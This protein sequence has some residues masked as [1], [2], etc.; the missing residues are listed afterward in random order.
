MIHVQLDESALDSV[1]SDWRRAC[2]EPGVLAL[3]P[4]AEKDRLTVLQ[5]VCRRLG[6]PL[7]GA[8]FPALVTPAGFAS[9]GA[10]LLRLD[11]AAPTALVTG[12]GHD[13]GR[14][15]ARLADVVDGLL[16]GQGKTRHAPTLYLFF[17]AMLPNIAST[18]A[19]LYLR[20]G[21]R[22]NYAGVNAG[23]ERFQPM[24]CLFD[25]RQCLGDGVLCL[26]L[27]GEVTT[28]LDHGF[29]QP[30]MATCTTVTEGNRIASINGRPA[31]DV[32]RELIR[33]HYAID[34]TPENFYEYGVHFPFGLLESSKEMAVRIPVAI[35]GDGS[36]LC[37][38]EV[39][40]GANL[41][42]MKAP[43]IWGNAYTDRIAAE[44][45]RESIPV[46]ERKFLFFYCAG[47]RTHIGND[48]HYEIAALSARLGAARF[49]GALS[50][51]EIG[52]TRNDGYPMFQNATLVCTPWIN[53]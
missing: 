25:E 42:V 10:W 31:F 9:D 24:P 18:L 2:P 49:G 37:V 13:A 19:A 32:Y 14:D 43:P 15:A 6:V 29:S 12:L 22:V 34:L 40:T 4:E 7:A 52:S 8:I 1:L 38:G 44:V 41:V 11:R 50:L 27:S 35:E 48:A 26:L 39:P 28:I 3:V 20:V 51:G 45:S 5:S 23:S 53:R 17:D 33:E 36:L 46:A 21:D 47:R 16:A 30:A